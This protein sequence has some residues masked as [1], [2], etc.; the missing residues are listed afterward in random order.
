MDIGELLTRDSILLPRKAASYSAA[1]EIIASHLSYL[2]ELRPRQIHRILL[3]REEK[4]S[5]GLGHGVALPH[6]RIE[7]LKSIHGVFMRL[8]EPVDAGAADG[9][10][11]DMVFTLLAPES[12]NAGYLK[13]IGKIATILRDADKRALLRSGDK[14]VVYATLTSEDA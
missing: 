3:E 4:G 14:D 10:P 6:A 5:T 9:K 7:G 1:L 12:A 2:T 11:V 8:V 13:A